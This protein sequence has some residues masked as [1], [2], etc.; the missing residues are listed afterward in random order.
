MGA[1]DFVDGLKKLGF[2]P[3]E[4]QAEP[5]VVAFGYRVL[6]GPRAGEEVDLAFAV[7]GDFP[8]QCPSGPHVRPHL[9]PFNSNGDSHPKGAVH[10]ARDGV[11]A[12]WQ[13][14]SRPFP[15]WASSDHSVRTYMGHINHLFDTL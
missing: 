13:Y 6:L 1:Q 7:P 9:L 5:R 2:E 4:L 3:S 11:P 10:P 15:G 8:L 12:E 14:W